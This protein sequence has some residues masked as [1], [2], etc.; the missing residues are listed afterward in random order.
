[1]DPVV[2]T[3][4]LY[5]AAQLAI[6]IVVS[7]RVRT[8]DDYLLAG[9]RLGYP[10]AVFSI[11]AT[12]FGAEACIG[13]A[14]SIYRSGLSGGRAEPFGYAFCLLLMGLFFA[15]RL[16]RRKYT[17]VADLFR[18]RFSPAVE[19]TAALV[20]VPGSILWAAAQI[21]AFGQILSASGRIELETALALAALVVILYTMFGGLLA[22][23]VT[24][25]VQGSV[26]IVGLVVLA[27]VVVSALGGIEATI[28]RIEPA[29]LALGSSDRPLLEVLEAWAIPILG[30]VMAQELVQRVLAARSEQVATRS[31]LAATALYLVVGLLPVGLGLLGPR[32]VPELADPEQLLPILA[33]EYL[34]TFA[35]ALFAG[36][37]VSAILS[38]VDSTL[39]VA[40]SLLSH[41]VVLSLRPGLG[42]RTKVALARGGVLVA[43]VVAYLIA[44]IAE[45][46]YLLVES[47]S[48]FGS[49]GLFVIFV[50]GLFS[51][52]GRTPSALAALVTGVMISIASETVLSLRAPF[53]TSVAGS[54]VAY[55]AFAPFGAPLAAVADEGTLAGG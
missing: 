9:R 31:S 26:L 22:D 29:R 34:P 4:G 38:T 12:W 55:L 6:G 36:A 21:R 30:S 14:G 24:D 25:I 7:R 43:G 28:V 49:S 35:Y 32:L 27:A 45:G 47:A 33:R 52:H 46:V 41:N 11:F 1:M 42:E 40:S 23:A 10:L 20:M 3:I 39:L 15:K 50:L 5:V 48:S 54:F 16:W 13:A 37:L 19:R 8:E 51:R 44:R 53:L 17:T 18:E 2:L